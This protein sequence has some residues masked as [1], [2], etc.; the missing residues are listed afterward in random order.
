MRRATLGLIVPSRNTVVETEFHRMVPQDVHVVSARA[1]TNVP[2]KWGTDAEMLA[3][4]AAIQQGEPDAVRRVVHAE[5]DVVAIG[6][7]ATF[8]SLA[9][10][11]QRKRDYEQIAGR[12]VVFWIDAF[13]DA[14]AR[15]GVKKRIAILGPRRPTEGEYKGLGVIHDMGLDPVAVDGFGCASAAEIAALTPADI[16]RGIESVAPNAE[17]VCLLGTNINGMGIVAAAERQIGKPVLHINTVLVWHALR[18]RGIADRREG[19][20]ALFAEY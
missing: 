12:P 5:P 9:D 3:M 8:V 16:M 15:L 10:H 4:A 19:L 17:A 13:R 14:F 18:Q 2:R 11:D 6:E 20:G 1:V 7:T